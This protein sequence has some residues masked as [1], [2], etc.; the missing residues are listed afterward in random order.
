MKSLRTLAMVAIAS[1]AYVAVAHEGHDHNKSG[2]VR[3]EQKPW[4]IAGKAGD[5][6]RTIELTMSDAMRFTP[7][8]N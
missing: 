4:G 3:M 1:A 2:P 6:R 7:R 5:A 8:S